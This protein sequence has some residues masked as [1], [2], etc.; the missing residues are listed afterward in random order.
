MTL[1]KISPLW[2]LPKSESKQDRWLIGLLYG[3]AITAGT[4]AILILGFLLFETWPILRRV[5]L[6]RFF[7]DTSWHPT[8]QLY[9]LSPMLLGTILSSLGAIVLAAPLGI[10]SAAFCQFYAPPLLKVVYRRLLELLAGIPSVV[11]GFWGLVVLVPLLGQLHP[12][13]QS[14]LT[15]I[16]ILTLMILPTMALMTQASFTEVPQ[17]Y[18]HGAIAMGLSRWTILQQIMIPTARS[19]ILTGLILSVGRALGET[20]ALLMVCGNVVQVPNSLFAPIRTL[21]ANIALEMAYATGDHRAA[22]FVSGIILM[23]TI[24]SLVAVTEV[25]HPGEH[26]HV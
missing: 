15:G 26:H 9:N 24:I 8:S 3:L 7:T 1:S 14:L 12:P 18:H 25:L 13:G 22:L 4:I 16:L 19:G 17:T 11:Y 20:M 23:V 2:S 5:G 10:F 6:L 21:T